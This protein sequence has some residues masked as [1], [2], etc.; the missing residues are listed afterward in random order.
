M[1][2]PPLVTGDSAQFDIFCPDDTGAG[3]DL[4]GVG[5]AVTVKIWDGEFS[6]LKTLA[7]DV[8]PLD[9]TGVLVGQAT[10]DVLPADSAQWQA[11]EFF[12]AWTLNP[13][14]PAPFLTLRVEVEVVN[15]DFRRTKQDTIRIGP[16][17]VG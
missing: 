3:I 1:I 16:E 8:T 5:V 12:A 17:G 4:T 13:F 7:D 6:I 9:Q 10:V 15:G 14:I 11:N 2:N